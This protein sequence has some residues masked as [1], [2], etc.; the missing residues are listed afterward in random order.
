MPM[1]NYSSTAAEVFFPVSPMNAFTPTETP[2][3]RPLNKR[4]SRTSSLWA[5]AVQQH[6][7]DGVGVSALGGGL[8][9]GVG[10]GGVAGAG[11]ESVPSGGAGVAI[12]VPAMSVWDFVRD[13]NTTLPEDGS[14]TSCIDL[15][16][17]RERADPQS[18]WTR[19]CE[20]D[21]HPRYSHQQAE[22][23]NDRSDGATAICIVAVKPV[24]GAAGEGLHDPWQD[25]DY[26]QLRGA[27]DGRRLGYSVIPPAPKPIG[28]RTTTD[29]KP[30]EEAC[31]KCGARV[32]RRPCSCRCR[33]RKTSLAK[34]Q[35]GSTVD[36]LCWIYDGIPEWTRLCEEGRLR[37]SQLQTYR[38]IEAQVVA[39]K[40]SEL[41]SWY[42]YP[43]YYSPT[44][45]YGASTAMTLG[46]PAAAAAGN[47]YG[48]GYTNIPGMGG[49]A[50]GGSGG[51]EWY[52]G[53]P[54]P[55]QRPPHF[56]KKPCC[57]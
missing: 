43:T 19:D 22:T 6:G 46:V 27:D 51:W 53:A 33:A 13:D 57:G 10:M 37:A 7:A 28:N 44:H 32:L 36:E 21:D 5:P 29:R 9:M 18:G 20:T 8:G 25:L 14:L 23:Q 26:G 48:Y 2:V 17:R 16:I 12:N 52:S 45:N 47:Y 49:G 4:T 31:A 41:K 39:K 56:K 42:G 35:Q 40:K 15:R 30:L 38:N 11:G 54:G 55:P 3:V 50:A 34:A 1:L 24:Y